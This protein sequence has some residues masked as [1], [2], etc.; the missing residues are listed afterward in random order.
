MLD[1]P[2]IGL[3]VWLSKPMGFLAT[4]FTVT[5]GSHPARC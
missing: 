1:R 4:C 5:A 3:A 2:I